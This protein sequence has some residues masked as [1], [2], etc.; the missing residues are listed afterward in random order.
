[1]FQSVPHSIK[2]NNTL[3]K[4]LSILHEHIES[5]ELNINVIFGN[6]SKE[7]LSRF[8]GKH[9]KATLSMSLLLQRKKFFQQLF[10]PPKKVIVINFH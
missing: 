10:F 3:S 6:F 9:R 4:S 7:I 8:Q 1:M 5:I 2:I